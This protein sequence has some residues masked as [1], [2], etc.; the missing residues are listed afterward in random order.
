[1][2][3]T[4]I[5]IGASSGIGEHIVRKLAAR[6]TTVCAV[7]RRKE[8]LEA[9]AKDWPG[10]IHP[11]VHDVRDYDAAPDLYDQMLETLGGKLD[12]FIYNAGV[13]PPVEES[14]YNWDKDRLMMEV[15]LMGAVRWFNLA[16]PTMEAAR[17]GTLVGVSSVA[18]DR[19]RRGS[20]M[21]TASKA[22][23]TATMEALRNRLDRYGVSV[24]T[25]KPGP[26]RTDM[27]AGMQLPLMIEAH[28]AAEGILQLAERGTGSGYVPKTWMPIMNVIKV[29]PSFIFRKTNI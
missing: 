5:V 1:M 10:R 24:V 12:C 28:E 22:G 6:G 19:G 3:Q 27:T 16:A 8:R 18:G 7:A 14:E 4:A 9:I 26:V 17:S 11:V 2:F 15:N 20:P 25:A 21:Y 23:L 13:M 29:V